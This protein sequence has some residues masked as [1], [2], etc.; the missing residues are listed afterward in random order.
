MLSN[1][2]SLRPSKSSHQIEGK[3][4]T[5]KSKKGSKSSKMKFRLK[6]HFSG[7][8]YKKERSKTLCDEDKPK[9][10]IISFK[11]DHRHKGSQAGSTE[12]NTIFMHHDN[13]FNEKITKKSMKLSIT[14]SRKKLKKN[15]KIPLIEFPNLNQSNSPEIVIRGVHNFD[16]VNNSKNFH[17]KSKSENFFLEKIYKEIEENME[18]SPERQKY[19]S[20]KQ[21]QRRYK[22]SKK[23][24]HSA[25][26]VAELAKNAEQLREETENSHKLSN[27]QSPSRAVEGINPVFE[28]REFGNDDLDPFNNEIYLKLQKMKKLRRKKAE[29]KKRELEISGEIERM[30]KS[31][32]KRD[33]GNDAGQLIEVKNFSNKENN[34]FQKQANIQREIPGTP[35]NFENVGDEN[36]GLNHTPKIKKFVGAKN[37]PGTKMSLRRSRSKKKKSQRGGYFLDFVNEKDSNIQISDIKNRGGYLELQADDLNEPSLSP[38]IEGFMCLSTKNSRRRKD[39]SK[40]SKKKSRSPKS[41]FAYSYNKKRQRKDSRTC[42]ELIKKIKDRS[43]S[44]KNK[45]KGKIQKHSQNS[46][47]KLINWNVDLIKKNTALRNENKSL[48]EQITQLDN[49]ITTTLKTFQ[50]KDQERKTD[51]I[52]QNPNPK[53]SEISKKVEKLIFYTSQIRLEM[54]SQITYTSKIEEELRRLKTLSHYYPISNEYVIEEIGV[55]VEDTERS[56]SQQNVFSMKASQSWH[57]GLRPIIVENEAIGDSVLVERKLE[58]KFDGFSKEGEEFGDLKV[59]TPESRKRQWVEIELNRGAGGFL[60]TDVGEDSFSKKNISQYF[61]AQ[62]F[63]EPND[64]GLKSISN[65][66]LMPDASNTDFFSAKK[67]Q[68]II[69]NSNEKSFNFNKSPKTPE[70]QMIKSKEQFILREI[71]DVDQPIHSPNLNNDNS[72]AKTQRKSKELIRE[73]YPPLIRQ[74]EDIVSGFRKTTE[75]E[76]E[77][78]KTAKAIHAHFGTNEYNGDIPTP[79]NVKSPIKEHFSVT[80]LPKHLSRN[81]SSIVN[82]LTSLNPPVLEYNKILGNLKNLEKELRNFVQNENETFSSID[83]LRTELQTISEKYE[84]LK[85][86][87]KEKKKELAKKVAKY[88]CFDESLVQFKDNPKELVW[89]FKRLMLD[90]EMKSKQLTFMKGRLEDIQ[91]SIM[92]ETGAHR[93]TNPISQSLDCLDNTMTS[94]TRGHDNDQRITPLKDTRQMTRRKK[95]S[96]VNKKTNQ[97][98]TKRTHS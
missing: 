43:L 10:L 52:F 71:S 37:S 72:L 86:K 47:A 4:E 18:E 8:E 53:N 1:F 85:V 5:K 49:L 15:K 36:K 50:D 30:Q 67:N 60:E 64:D 69:Q 42:K 63:I 75:R 93:G 26:V 95:Q 16:S 78:R 82:T 28:S 70:N 31:S 96:L 23:R 58:N 61:G 7:M 2:K 17:R 79:L 24:S 91:G 80:E 12:E 9:K 88:K 14:P 54:E 48:Q 29:E 32:R 11:V 6:N 83:I 81:L 22:N 46:Y 65:L 73:T 44:R 77:D 84:T 56:E 62:N 20:Q 76:E 92:T 55:S 41:Y 94:M 21:A 68:Q 39:I 66:S 34:F 27:F 45:S 98:R 90:N 59:G 13:S 51:H 3:A 38:S 89:E 74:E 25:I 33:N 40:I 57:E 87:Y 35:Q 97:N 19:D